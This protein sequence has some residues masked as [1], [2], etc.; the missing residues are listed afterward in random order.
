MVADGDAP[1]RPSSPDT[2]CQVVSTQYDFETKTDREVDTDAALAAIGKGPYTW[3]DVAVEDTD[4]AQA[5][6]DGLGLV[7]SQVIEDALCANVGIHQTRFENYVYFMLIGVRPTDSGFEMERLAVIVGEHFMLTIHRDEPAFL[8]RMRREVHSDFVNFAQSPSFLVY[9]IWDHLT[10][11]YVE[12]QTR[13]ES[14]VGD[15]QKRLMGGVS[16]DVFG[17]VSELGT[18][19]LTLRKILLPARAVLLELASRRSP[20]ISEATQPFL[21]NMAGTVDRVLQDL[22]VDREILSDSLNL[23]V[24]MVGHR[25]NGFMSRL[26][27]VSMVFLPL[28][29]LSGV[30]GMNFHHLPLAEWYFGFHAFWAVSALLVMILLAAMKL[31]GVI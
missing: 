9:D 27:I 1:S 6:L 31:R 16:E 28:T 4:R 29:F 24:S 2:G 8:A 3:I 25:T 23:Y 10:E 7:D 5:F 12:I 20:F 11:S 18:D 14:L 22:L 21:A 26:T 15:L 13:F 30:Y 17:R 19:L